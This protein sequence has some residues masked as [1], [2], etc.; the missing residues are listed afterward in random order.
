MVTKELSRISYWIVIHQTK[1][2]PKPTFYYLFIDSLETP[3]D[4]EYPS[5]R[6]HRPPPHVVA[7]H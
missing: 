5:I 1:F 3:N 7:S 4:S 2:V 6:R